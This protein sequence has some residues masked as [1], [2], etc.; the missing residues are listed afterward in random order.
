[1]LRDFGVEKCKSEL[2][3]ADDNLRLKQEIE[4]SIQQCDEVTLSE[5]IDEARLLGS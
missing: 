5:K 1:L 3:D 4:L 2:L